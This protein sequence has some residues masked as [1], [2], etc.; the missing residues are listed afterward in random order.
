MKN[1][2]ISSSCSVINDVTNFLFADNTVSRVVIKSVCLDVLNP[3]VA[4]LASSIQLNLSK[5]LVK[6]KHEQQNKQ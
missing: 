3:S 6:I 1:T 2:L 4:C 5:L